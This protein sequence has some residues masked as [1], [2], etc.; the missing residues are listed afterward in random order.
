VWWYKPVILALAPEREIY[1]D[2]KFKGILVYT[3]NKGLT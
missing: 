3:G 1:E 2:P